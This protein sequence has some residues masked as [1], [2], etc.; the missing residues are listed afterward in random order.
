MG[1]KEGSH[2]QEGMTTVPRAEDGYGQVEN[3]LTGYDREL[4]GGGGGGGP[5][6][7]HTVSFPVP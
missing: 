4:L 7:T 2:G 1:S 3:R 6:H 5:Q